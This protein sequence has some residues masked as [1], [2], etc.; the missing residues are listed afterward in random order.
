[1]RRLLWTLIALA[2]VG[3]FLF[4][5]VPPSSAKIDLAGWDDLAARTIPG[6]YHVHTTRSDGHGDKAA[7]AAAAARAGLKFVVLTDHGDGTRPP[8]PPEYLSG[9]LMIDAVEISTDDGHYVAIDMPRAPYPLGGAGEAVVEDVHRLGGFGIAAHPDSPKAALRWSETAAPIDGIEWINADSEWRG[10]TRLRLVRAGVAYLFRPAPA[11]ATLLDRPVTLDRW[12]TLLRRRRVIAL[13]GAD[14]HGGP[15]QRAEDQGRTLFGTAG[16]P[17]YEASFR[18]LSIRAIADRAP[19]GNA[20]EDAGAI[21]SAIRRGHVF[22]LIDAVAAPAV[23]D[24]HAV[25]SGASVTL[26]A[27]ASLP[28][29]GQLVLFGP[30]G[31]VARS[32]GE[33]RREV[34]AAVAACYRAE[35]QL[36]GAPG[37]PPVPWLVSNPIEVGTLAS[38][39]AAISGGAIDAAIAPFPWRIE[40]DPGSSAIL[41]TS[42]HSADLEYTLAAGAR[43]SQFVALATDVAGQTFR[44]IDLGLAADRPSRVSVQVRAADGR[45]WSRSFYVDPGG[46]RVHAGLAEMRPVGSQGGGP[47]APGLAT[48]VLLVVDLT[49]ASPG[50]RG[51]LTVRSSALVN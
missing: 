28:H 17:S 2:A 15:G 36:P 7:V 9:V 37:Q 11:L 40:K 39:P 21:L 8:D 1:V 16:I 5:L 47:P 32:A 43:S 33:L 26:V 27:R 42:A 31:E 48:S 18:E 50:R 35:V 45:R 23:L 46:S 19:G 44:A 30:D 25:P 22:T 49:N 29:E 14:A 34:P 13:G 6:A 12:N 3:V 20:A 24:F 51:S 4:A 38:E 41:R 10:E